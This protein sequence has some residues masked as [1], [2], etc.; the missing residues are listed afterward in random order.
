MIKKSFAK[1]YATFRQVHED[2]ECGGDD[3][4]VRDR[5]VAALYQVGQDLDSAA[6]FAGHLEAAAGRVVR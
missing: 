3:L 4:N 2:L 1:T 6:T 5:A